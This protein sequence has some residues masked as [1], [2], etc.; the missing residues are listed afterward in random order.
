[1]YGSKYKTVPPNSTA[2]CGTYTVALG[3]VCANVRDSGFNLIDID[4]VRA[5]IG[6]GD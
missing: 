2:L 4:D 1:M 3:Q 6:G 5:A